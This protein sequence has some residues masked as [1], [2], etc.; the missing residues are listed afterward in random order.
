VGGSARIINCIT[1]QETVNEEISEK[2]NILSANV[3]NKLRGLMGGEGKKK[4]CR[5]T[6]KMGDI[7]RMGGERLKQKPK[8]V[9][10]PQ[11]K[12]GK[13][14]SRGRPGSHGAPPWGR[15]IAKGWEFEREPGHPIPLGCALGK[16]LDNIGWE[17]RQSVPG[18]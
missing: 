16:R 18:G 13:G 3:R 12:R 8:Y 6:C 17:G 15:N 7:R 10:N 2:E 5:E 4:V 14:R 1:G 9:V 11:N